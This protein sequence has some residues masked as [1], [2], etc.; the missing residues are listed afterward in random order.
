MGFGRI[1]LIVYILF[2][3]WNFPLC[4]YDLFKH[5]KKRK[6][7]ESN[8]IQF[9][10]SFLLFTVIYPERRWERAARL[11]S[12]ACYLWGKQQFWSSFFMGIILLVRLFFSS[13]SAG[14]GNCSG[15]FVGHANLKMGDGTQKWGVI[16]KDWRFE[17]VNRDWKVE[18]IGERKKM[19]VIEIQEYL[20]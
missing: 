14:S 8:S 9:H 5:R 19:F 7:V 11:W 3:L 1:R 6:T 4:M 16:Q 20:L 12:V 15:S 10:R 2:Y 17:D 13:F 18:G